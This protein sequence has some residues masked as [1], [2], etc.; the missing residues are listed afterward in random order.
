MNLSF[1]LILYSLVISAS[2]LATDS[3]D[4]Y[5]AVCDHRNYKPPAGGKGVK[6][7]GMPITARSEHLL[8]GKSGLD[9]LGV[10]DAATPWRYMVTMNCKKGSTDLVD[11]VTKL[12]T[13][14]LPPEQ[15]H[16]LAILIGINEKIGS[17]ADL[18]LPFNWDELTAKRAELEALGVPILFV[19]TP[20]S[21]YRDGPHGTTP[22]SIIRN[23]RQLVNTTP[24]GR[25]RDVLTNRLEKEDSAH[26]FPF[27]AMRTHLLNNNFTQAFMAKFSRS[28]PVYFHIQ[29]S[30]FTNLKTSPQFYSFGAPTE[31]PIVS[32]AEQYL[33]KK[34]DSLIS[35]MRRRNEHYPVIIGGAHVYDPAEILDA[36]G[37]SAKQWTR[38]SSELGNILKH[39]LAVFQPYGVYFHEPNTMCLAPQTVDY[40]YGKT[41]EMPLL[42][43]RLKH[44]GISFGIDSE[45]QGFTRSLFENMDDSTC[46]DGMIFSSTIVE[47]T[48]MKR[49]GRPFNIR[50][51][52]SYDEDLKKFRNWKSDDI[53]AI[54]GMPQEITDPNAWMCNVSTSFADHRK[55][56]GRTL[57]C[58]LFS[59]FD[60]HAL[61]GARAKYAASGFYETLVGY[62]A[63]IT[64]QKQTIKDTFQS[65]LAAYDKLGQGKL[66]AF[67][68]LSAAW[69]SGQAMR[70]MFLDNLVAPVM[71]A[72]RILTLPALLH[73]RKLLADRLN[74]RVDR[75]HPFPNPFIISLL[76]LDGVPRRIP[77]GDMLVILVE[78]VQKHTKTKKQIHDILGLSAPVIKAIL[79]TKSVSPTT[80]NKF[81]SR[82]EPENISIEFPALPELA[83][84]TYI[85]RLF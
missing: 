34:Y 44:S 31:A 28:K 76:D 39:I 73:E 85:Q 17:T 13:Q 47:A 74:H 55:K 6:P 65:L 64:E 30:D 29:D 80:R 12:A 82:L 1:S 57:L 38:L 67:Y 21:T 41:D 45:V 54:H 35:A 2:V 53:V 46:R 8:F 56:D 50:F 7:Q 48:S 3:L 71:T 51:S 33:Y 4:N 75:G 84:Q 40:L 69:E 62:D 23:I 81:K 60:P 20:W 43:S 16:R 52:G 19:Y 63:K 36:V 42:F 22:E 77:A 14:L 79:E 26:G 25:V 83:R 78:S 11:L 59:A 37:I 18:D 61:T 10:V 9:P 27:G 58:N 24:V 5:P 66:T 49:T 15:R 68:I 72:G 32:D 70:M